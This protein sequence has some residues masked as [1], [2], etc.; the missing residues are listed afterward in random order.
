MKPKGY[1][2]TR[3]EKRH[4]SKCADGVVRTFTTLESNLADILQA[5]KDV[6]EFRC[7]VLLDNLDIGQFTTDFVVRLMNGDLRVYECAYRKQ[8][9]KPRTAKLLDVSRDYW[10]RRGVDDWVLVV[11]KKE[12]ED[13]KEPTD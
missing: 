1:K 10:H 9:L 7:N 12:V 4:L 3:C 2:R 5:D 11:E 6:K 13:G 8:L